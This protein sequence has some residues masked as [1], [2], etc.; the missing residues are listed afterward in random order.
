M[1]IEIHV[2]VHAH[3]HVVLQNAYVLQLHIIL[4]IRLTLGQN[5]SSG[6]DC[7]YAYNIKV[8]LYL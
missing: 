6:Q 2:H 5:S 4:L 1:E 3:I 8:Q 7:L